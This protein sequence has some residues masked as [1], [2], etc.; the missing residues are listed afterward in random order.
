M[1][2]QTRTHGEGLVLEQPH[3]H[4]KKGG[5]CCLQDAALRLGLR[6]FLKGPNRL[7]S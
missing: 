5:Q 7:T 2:L 6:H 3:L 4:P 1:Q